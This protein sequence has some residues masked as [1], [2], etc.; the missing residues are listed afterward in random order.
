M[1]VLVLGGAGYIGSNAVD[2]LI[3]QGYEVVVVDNL[4]TGFKEAVH[5]RAKFYAIDIRNKKLLRSV[6]EI[7]NIDSVMYF[8][9]LSLGRESV[10]QP[11]KYFN[12][13]VY[14]TQIVL[15]VMQ[16]FNIRHIVF[17]SSASVYGNTEM[18]PVHELIPTAPINP[19]GCSKVIMET[20]MDWVSRS[21]NLTFVSMRYFNVAGANKDSTLGEVRPRLIPSIL[22]VAQRKRE[23]ITVFGNT[24]TT[25]DG[26]C[27][28]DYIHVLDLV[29]AH[30]L[31]LE[32]LKCGGASEIFNLGSSKGYSNLEVINVAEKV[33]GKKI[34]VEIV[35][36]IIGDASSLV[37]SNKKIKTILGWEPKYS[38]L[39]EIIS[40]SWRWQKNSPDGYLK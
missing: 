38:G 40:D 36:S 16:E 39:E 5:D 18:S 34:P 21:S 23:K 33:T 26:T 32:Y 25:H 9:A 37:A 19:Y 17:S 35:T 24:Y 29:E 8:A 27:I 2:M 13:N 14:G 1:S 30:I 28:R 7:E 11:L 20:M 6:F 10:E 4:S 15:E 12:N 3:S 22:E 31:A